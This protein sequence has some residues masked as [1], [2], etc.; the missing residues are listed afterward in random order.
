MDKNISQSNSRL[1]QVSKPKS[2]TSTNIQS[3][4][5]VAKNTASS[6]DHGISTI[7]S[8]SQNFKKTT[9]DFLKGSTKPRGSHEGYMGASSAYVQ[10]NNHGYD[11]KANQQARNKKLTKQPVVNEFSKSSFNL[12]SSLSNNGIIKNYTGC[13]LTGSSKSIMDKNLKLNKLF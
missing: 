9:N 11:N 10:V 8:E 1:R 13:S 12:Q 7:G 6:K 3:S 4:N 5:N 2:E